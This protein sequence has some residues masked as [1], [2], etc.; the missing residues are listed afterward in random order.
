MILRR[1]DPVTWMDE[2]ITRHGVQVLLPVNTGEVD[3]EAEIGMIKY[4]L[5]SYRGVQVL[6]ITIKE[7]EAGEKLAGTQLVTYGGE[8]EPLSMIDLEIEV[9]VHH[10]LNT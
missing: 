1:Y 4:K 8:E 5:M 6:L 10:L 2:E 9:N 7:A 3:L